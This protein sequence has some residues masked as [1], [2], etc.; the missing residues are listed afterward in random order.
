MHHFGLLLS[1]AALAACAC[2]S[3]ASDRLRFDGVPL[4]SAEILVEHVEVNP[5]GQLKLDLGPQGQVTISPWPSALPGQLRAQY[6]TL[7]QTAHPAGPVQSLLLRTAGGKE[8]WLTLV[9]NGGLNWGLLPGIRLRGTTGGV[10]I[11]GLKIEIS[12]TPGKDVKF[13]DAAMHCWQFG[14]LAVRQPPVM[15]G[16]AQEGEPRADWY[17]RADVEC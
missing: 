10:K 12:V 17:L 14:L 16:I 13:R 2:Q 11:T 6:V 3:V 4:E 5:A 7:R 9:A 8:P 1:A 15:K